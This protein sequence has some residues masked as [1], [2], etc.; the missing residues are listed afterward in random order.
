MRK[1]SR[2]ID[3]QLRVGDGATIELH[4]FLDGELLVSQQWPTREV[5]LTETASRLRDLQRAGWTT[6]W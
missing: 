3:G 5:A 6:H 2:F 1:D 4:Y